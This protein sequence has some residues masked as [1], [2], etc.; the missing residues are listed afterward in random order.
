M[1]W[2]RYHGTDR[3]NPGGGV[4]QQPAGLQRDVRCGTP[5]PRRWS[6]GQRKVGVAIP[7]QRGG[8]VG[9]HDLPRD[10]CGEL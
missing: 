10:E 4:L 2:V 8:G 6:I 5:I 1:R 7:S 9:V 3:D